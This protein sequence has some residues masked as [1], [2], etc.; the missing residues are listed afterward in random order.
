MCGSQV[1]TNWIPM[2]S[3]RALVTE[4]I[5][6]PW[7]TTARI[8]CTLKTRQ[9]GGTYPGFSFVRQR[10]RVLQERCHS[11]TVVIVVELSLRTCSGKVYR[12]YDAPSVY[13]GRSE[14]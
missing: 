8:G 4:S 3:L 2:C 13:G 7:S 1:G 5:L 11:L 6:V 12:G 10:L 14:G 9:G